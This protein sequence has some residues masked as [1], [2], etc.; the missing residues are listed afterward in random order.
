MG[1]KVPG[2]L[3]LSQAANGPPWAP[4][5]AM[6]R[7]SHPG[8]CRRRGGVKSKTPAISTSERSAPRRV[9]C[10]NIL[11]WVFS[12]PAVAATPTA[13]DTIPRAVR[14]PESHFFL[15]FPSLRMPGNVKEGEGGGGVSSRNSRRCRY[16]GVWVGRLSHGWEGLC[17][18]AAT[19]VVSDHTHPLQL[20]GTCS[21][22]PN[23]TKS[24]ACLAAGLLAISRQ[25][26]AQGHGIR[27]LQLPDFPTQSGCISFADT[28]LCTCFYFCTYRHHWAGL[29][30]AL[31]T[32]RVAKHSCLK[33]ACPTAQPDRDRRHRS[34]LAAVPSSSFAGTR[35][36]E[37]LSLECALDCR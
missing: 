9:L 16:T 19:I 37:S 36:H 29:F 24:H 15:T 28:A 33:A 3:H 22:S 30:Q 7:Y 12:V 18:C 21:R 4:G 5:P 35:D 25:L 26:S 32:R 17:A 1:A 34:A 27:R 23:P 20:A 10:F 2:A 13:A 11:C 31:T 6:Y 8:S 14:H